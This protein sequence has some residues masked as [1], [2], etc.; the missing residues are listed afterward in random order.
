MAALALVGTF[1]LGLGVLAAMG[2]F[3]VKELSRMTVEE[4][5]KRVAAS[6]DGAVWCAY[7]DKLREAGQFGAAVKA[8][9]KAVEF[10]PELVE[11]R[12]NAGVALAQANNPD[13]FFAYVGRL[14]INYP[15]VAVDLMERGE[16][17]GLR[18][19][20]RWGPAEAGA[21]AQA[22]D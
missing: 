12:L 6:R 19:D 18:G 16:V 14:A 15:K 17:R 21:R 10:G 11:A 5:E 4:L 1:G 13:A 3:R 22:V 2:Q 9:E 20:A 8:Y 7:G